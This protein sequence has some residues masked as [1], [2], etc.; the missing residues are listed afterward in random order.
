MFSVALDASNLREGGG[1]THLV[2]LLSAAHPQNYGIKRVIVWGNRNTVARINERAWL[3]LRSPP[4]MEEGQ[5]ARARWQ[6]HTLPEEA[7]AAGCDLL[8][9]PGGN[10][11][12]N[13]HP[14]VTM[15]RNMLP[16]DRIEVARYGWGIKRFRL[17]LLRMMQARS[18]RRADGL[19]FLTHFARQSVL[20]ASG[21]VGAQIATISHGVSNNFS[22]PQRQFRSR[23]EFTDDAPLRIVYISHASPYKHQWHVI[24]ALAGLRRQTGLPLQFD[25]MGP[26]S[27]PASVGRIKAAIA[28]HDPQGSWA[29]LHPPQPQA[30]VQDYLAKADIGVFASS[31][32]NM[33]N[34]LLEKMAAGLPLAC[35]DRGPMPECLRDGGIYFNPEDPSS[36]AEALR[37]LIDDPVLRGNLS[38]RTRDLASDFN[39]QRCANETFAFLQRVI[40]DARTPSSIRKSSS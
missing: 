18:F 33:P 40:L 25:M 28:L 17:E 36:I 11:P 20:E 21:S 35:S 1:V 24:A 23:S 22:V 34:I 19:I 16:F 9:A 8:F 37:Q 6:R 26:H 29:Y 4:V 2:E 5:F 31:C 13:F 10:V 12:G 27:V 15:S 38:R 14:F 32:E 39:W 3:E 30:T 7:L